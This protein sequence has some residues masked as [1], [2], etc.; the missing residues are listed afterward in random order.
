MGQIQAMIS[1]MGWRQ[2][3]S[4][5]AIAAAVA[6]ALWMG[7]RYNR[8]KDLRPLF[9][10][11]S[12]E[13][14][15]AI[16]A[17]LRTTNV[18]YA[19][20]DDGAIMVPSARVAELRLDLASS[21]LP[22]TGRLGFELFDKTNFGATDFAEQVN[23]RRAVEGELE[24]S[25]MAIAVVEKARVHVTFPKESVFI[26]S[27]QPAK[28]SVML[29]LRP[30]GRLSPQNI[31]GITHLAASA[32]EGL[33]PENVSVLDMNGALLN[34][35]RRNIDGEEAGASD[36]R[37]EYRQSIEKDL[38]VKIRA[39][40]DPLLGAERYRAGV[41]ADVDFS[42]GEQSEETFEPEK[43]VMVHSQKTEDVSGS[44]VAA[45]GVPGTATSLP[46]PVER[47]A[48]T[49][50]GVARRTEN[51]TYQTSRLVKRITLPQGNLRR[52]SV[53]VL[54]D[55]SVRWEGNGAQAKRVIEAPPPERLKVVRD[56]LAG[57]IG[58]Q[59]Q[60]G[61]QILVESL[62]FE[63]TLHSA[64]PASS[65]PGGSA[66]APTGTFPMPVFLQ[67]LLKIAPLAVWL[68]AV[69]AVAVVLLVAVFWVI[70]R[71]RRKGG[72]HGQPRPTSQAALP[73]TD[74]ASQ[75]ESKAMAQLAA[76]EENRV[77]AEQ[78]LLASLQLPPNTKKTEILRKQIGES[79]KRDPQATAQLIRAWLNE[80]ER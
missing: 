78:E 31:Q 33:Q 19:I 10:S 8:E 12:P 45:G 23:Y 57:V 38:L 41:T 53:A 44:A 15:G 2:R 11:L 22:Q 66:N 18:P 34:R 68:G 28:A 52:V 36:A 55:Q 58:F 4:I 5:L 25:F 43:S 71:L 21:G 80:Q 79:A 54:L 70:R 3:I 24:R 35:P 16:V 67:P 59:E 76:N 72:V 27:R 20:R 40:L 75:L 7:V 61:D 48:S 73:A 6:A 74:H 69:A 30:G 1:S 9:T 64:P 26:E 17:K 37:L 32:V 56:V 14:S 49:R 39:T 77:R 42:S 63:A 65:G 50:G 46:R 60:R 47:T 51:T 29:K 13:D 62:P